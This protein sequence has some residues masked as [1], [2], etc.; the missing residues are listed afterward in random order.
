METDSKQPTGADAN[1]MPRLND[2]KKLIEK[3]SCRASMSRRL[4]N[5]SARTWK[6]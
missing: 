3:F 1:A 4:S 2:L 6:R 5:G